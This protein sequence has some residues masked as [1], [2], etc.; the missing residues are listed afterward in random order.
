MAKRLEKA[1]SPRLSASRHS[2][3]Q[4]YIGKKKKTPPLNE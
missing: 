3:P 2:M 1:M 4:F